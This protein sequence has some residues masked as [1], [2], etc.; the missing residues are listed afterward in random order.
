MYSIDILSNKNYEVNY[1]PEI[2][3]L[4]NNLRKTVCFFSSFLLFCSF[5]L[6]L[7]NQDPSR[8]IH[9]LN[10]LT[11]PTIYGSRNLPC[12]KDDLQYFSVFC[13]QF[14]THTGREI[15]LNFFPK[16]AILIK[17]CRYLQWHKYI[18]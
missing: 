4:S 17:F 5:S 14:D 11:H 7:L 13:K 8:R 18:Q 16:D 1:Y 9:E 6:K 2:R 15:F 3:Q 12:I 10:P